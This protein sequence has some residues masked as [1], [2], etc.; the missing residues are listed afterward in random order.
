MC[1]Q[2]SHHELDTSVEQ[3][4]LPSLCDTM[5]EADSDSTRPPVAVQTTNAGDRLYLSS[6]ALGS[7][8]GLLLFL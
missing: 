6:G 3:V 2:A 8:L 7:I 1:K 5:N 4:R